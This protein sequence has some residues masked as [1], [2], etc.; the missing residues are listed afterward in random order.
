M[1]VVADVRDIDDALET[2]F[3]RNFVKRR[4]LVLSDERHDAAQP[5]WGSEVE[6]VAVTCHAEVALIVLQP[7]V[8]CSRVDRGTTNGDTEAG[9]GHRSAAHGTALV[10]DC[11][12]LTRALNTHHVAAPLWVALL[13]QREVVRCGTRHQKDTERN[14]SGSHVEA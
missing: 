9:Q 14:K 4:L 5:L 12:P 8:E 13:V 2:N 7:S 1:R 6:V 10:A 3:S 11:V